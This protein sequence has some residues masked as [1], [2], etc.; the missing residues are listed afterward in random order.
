MELF[1][2]RSLCSCKMALDFLFSIER[3]MERSVRPP[4]KVD[5]GNSTQPVWVC[6]DFP[7]GL[8]S[9]SSTEF[10]EDGIVSDRVGTEADNF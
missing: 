3:M 10:G 5:H 7:L 4:T 1:I 6:L 8:N 2:D 9:P